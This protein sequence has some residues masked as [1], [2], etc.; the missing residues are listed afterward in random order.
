MPTSKSNH[1]SLEQQYHNL[2]RDWD[3]YKTSIPFHRRSRSTADL[4]SSASDF[5]SEF[6]QISCKNLE[7]LETVKQVKATEIESPLCCGNFTSSS[8]SLASHEFKKYEDSSSDSDDDG[9]EEKD[10]LRGEKQQWIKRLKWFFIGIAAVA[11]GVCYFGALFGL[12][13]VGQLMTPT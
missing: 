5:D 3:Q 8:S 11:V 2:R 4:P 6:F 7:D 9:L 13:D 12:D 10:I 1:I